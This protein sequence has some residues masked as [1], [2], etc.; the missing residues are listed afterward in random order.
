L[1]F[2]CVLHATIR[3]YL[4]LT[5]G[6]QYSVVETNQGIPN[7][8]ALIFALV[9][10]LPCAFAAGNLYGQNIILLRNAGIDQ[11]DPAYSDAVL[12]SRAPM[13]VKPRGRLPGG[14]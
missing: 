9:L 5:I 1:E 10:A 6:Y 12:R 4:I 13:P 11:P 14:W 7:M 2:N 8:K 3:F